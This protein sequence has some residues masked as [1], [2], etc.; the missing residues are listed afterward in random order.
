MYTWSDTYRSV[1]AVSQNMVN[2]IT[3]KTQLRKTL[4]G[5]LI[6]IKN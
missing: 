4:N 5:E 1:N 3:R 2:T 6:R